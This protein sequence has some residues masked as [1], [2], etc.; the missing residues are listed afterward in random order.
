MLLSNRKFF[1]SEHGVVVSFRVILLGT[2]ILFIA[3][4]AAPKGKFGEDLDNHACYTI[5]H[6]EAVTGRAYIK[7]VE[8]GEASLSYSNVPSK[9][10]SGIESVMLNKSE[11]TVIPIDKSLYEEYTAPLLADLNEIDHEARPIYGVWLS[12]FTF[13]IY[14]SIRPNEAKRLT[15]GCTET[16]LGMPY[17]DLTRKV[18]TG[19]TEWRN[20]KNSHTILISGFD[21]AYE[22]LKSQTSVYDLSSA[23]LNTDLIKSTT[24]NITCIDCDL[25]GPE[26]QKLYKSAKKTIE[27]TYDF[28]PIKES[29]LSAERERKGAPINEFMEQ[30]RQIGFKVGSADFGNCVLELN[31]SK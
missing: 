29:L 24:L 10:F 15:F 30:C 9:N 18:K 28:R 14:P 27:L 1:M 31:E 13:G 20:V 6:T 8:T 11:L 4:C 22:Y 2:I 26:E 25:L 23:I 3:G 5:G 19:K 7:T 21:K 17:E 12:V 16:Q